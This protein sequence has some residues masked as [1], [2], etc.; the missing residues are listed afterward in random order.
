MK[1]ISRLILGMEFV[2]NA[3]RDAWVTKLKN[4][5]ATLKSGMPTPTRVVIS[6]DEYEI[7]ERLPDQEITP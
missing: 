1:V 7:P 3:D 2:T 5:Y 4:G 6:A